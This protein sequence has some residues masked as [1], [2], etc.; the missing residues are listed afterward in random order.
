MVLLPRGFTYFFPTVDETR[1]DFIVVPPKSDPNHSPNT[2]VWYGQGSM[3]GG[4][5]A[6]EGKGM[7]SS[8]NNNQGGE[9]R[10][11]YKFSFGDNTMGNFCTFVL[12]MPMARPN[13]SPGR[14]VFM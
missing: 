10:D 11:C 6:G 12:G 9:V 7:I 8:S 2:A 3:R 13:D 4:A 1:G 14:F 5:E